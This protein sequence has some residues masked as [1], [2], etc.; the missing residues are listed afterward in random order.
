MKRWT[1]PLLVLLLL[2]ISHSHIAVA[3]E[4]AS[5]IF[6]HI[7][8]VWLKQPGN[9]QA[10]KAYLTHPIHTRAVHNFIKPLVKKITVYDIH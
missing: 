2:L 6:N 5:G 7:V 9:Q 3:D 4:Q 1:T 8:L 10:M